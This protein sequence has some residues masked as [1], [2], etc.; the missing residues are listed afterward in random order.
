VLQTLLVLASPIQIHTRD[1]I[2]SELDTTQQDW[3]PG[4]GDRFGQDPLVTIAIALALPEA[5]LSSHDL[6]E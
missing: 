4:S 3:M 1:E 2:L 6:H 5:G